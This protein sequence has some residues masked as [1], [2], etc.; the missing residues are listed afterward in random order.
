MEYT[1]NYFLTILQVF[2]TLSSILIIFMFIRFI[3]VYKKTK[4][5]KVMD[6]EVVKT[7]YI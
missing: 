6:L 7:I 3:I 2:L 1:G 4:R 5:R